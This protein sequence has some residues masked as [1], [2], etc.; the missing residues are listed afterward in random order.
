MPIG[1]LALQPAAAVPL[2]AGQTGMPCK[3]CHI[4]A[5]GPQLTPYGRNFKIKGYTLN[6]GEGLASKIP[7]AIWVQS[8]YENYQK[9][10]PTDQIT[11][12]YNGNNNAGVDAVSFFY[13]GRLTEH[14]GA[15][16]QFTYDNTVKAIAQ[17]N[18]DVR[19]IGDTELFGSDV[20]YGFSLNNAPGL[21]D[22]Y[23]SNYI[24]GYPYISPFLAIG[25]NA[26]P[27]LG[28]PASA[29]SNSV[30]IVG[31]TWID[32][33]IYVDLGG[34]ET[35]PPGL[36]KVLGETYTSGSSTG[37]EPYA[38]AQYAWFWGNNNA[39]VGGAFF[40]GRYNPTV[41]A[42]ARSS[43][44][45]FGHDTY[46]DFQIDNGYQY[47]GDEAKHVVTV[48]GF[49][50]FESQN[51]RG[52]SNPLNPNFGSSQPNNNVNEFREWITYYY[53]ATY[54]VTVAFDK[55]WGKR[56]EGLYNTGQDGTG[57]IKGSPNSQFFIFEGDWVPFGKE[58]SWLRPFANVKIGLQYTLYTEFNGTN[59]NYDGFGRN[60]GDNNT[61][62]LFA[63][64][65]F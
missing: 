27:I 40:Y 9:N 46:A 8:G 11:P 33:H 24:W 7:F 53:K 42:K 13:G 43:D 28:S 59:N 60:A 37:I 31:Y 2:F 54:G 38:S 20:D 57:S 26:G 45:E 22:P 3:Q 21:S 41:G 4:G 51:L 50:T 23:N 14:V 52:T 1:L 55:I 29:Q 58:D 17:D 48:D 64:T 62:F 16:I 35:Q 19:Y 6:G 5:L 32:Q 25:P 30:G 10:I 39:H 49:L 15:F 44:G 47:I 18:S 63:W 65:V 61:L 56:N 36:Q 34:Y 12:H